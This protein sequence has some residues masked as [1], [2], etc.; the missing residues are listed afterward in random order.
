MNTKS[1]TPVATLFDATVP[2]SGTNSSPGT[3]LPANAGTLNVPGAPLS[4][5]N[6]G[7][8]SPLGTGSPI[9]FTGWVQVTYTFQTTGAYTITFG[10]TNTIDQILDLGLAFAGSNFGFNPAIDTNAPF[11]LASGVGSTVDADFEGGVLRS[12]VASVGSNFLVGA[13]STNTLDVF[14]GAR[15]YSGNFFNTV[16]G[17]GTL[18]VADTVGGGGV[19]FTGGIGTAADPLGLFQNF[20]STTVSGSLFTQTMSNQGGANLTV[21]NGGKLSAGAI[22]NAGAIN[23][24]AGGALS[25]TSLNN[26]GSVSMANGLIGD[27]VT[28]SGGYVGGA[29][30]V[31]GADVDLGSNLNR[32]DRIVAASVSGSSAV[33]LR[34]VAANKSYF[35]TP[36]VV[37][38]GASG[39]A[40]FTAA[41]DSA[42]AAALAPQG[43]VQYAFQKLST[44]PNDWGVV[45]KLNTAAASSIAA[46]AN[47]FMTS[48]NAGAFP[49]AYELLGAPENGGNLFNVWSRAG[50]GQTNVKAKSSPS[51]AY[52]SIASQTVKVSQDNLE[53]GADVAAVRTAAGTLRIGVMGG[54]LH[55]EDN[56]GGISN[57]VDAPFYGAYAAMKWAGLLGDIQVQH[58]DGTLIA[59][60]RL[61]S[62]DKSV[63]LDRLEASLSAPIA[64]GRNTLEPFAQLSSSK[65]KLGTVALTGGVGTLSV[66]DPESKLAEVGLRLTGTHQTSAMTL[67]PYASAA[68]VHEMGD[69][70]LSKFTPTGGAASVSMLTSRPG[71]FADIRVGVTAH[72]KDFP[73]EGYLTGVVRT[74]EALNG[75]E[76]NGGVRIRF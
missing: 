40:S 21:A 75:V 68:W 45:A 56:G 32:S 31:I 54:W 18:I 10:A 30:S 74:G 43:V 29:G 58:A 33:S 6:G 64:L 62:N 46:S 72:S 41:N 28:L 34:N 9:R 17:P 12:D 49:D 24:A 37:I 67:S 15:T 50:H 65:M 47:A 4:T 63:Q 48:W 36:I 19:N 57:R 55:S 42:T 22:N 38:S 39:S 20:A 61:S 26:S 7:S 69:H 2:S 73:L 5:L 3:G 66:Q 14:G 44:G 8:W 23:I 27:R 51:D 53:L 71:D 25:A 16:D 70:G 11:Y 13:T 76:L 59:D 52:S 35:S 1:G 60:Q